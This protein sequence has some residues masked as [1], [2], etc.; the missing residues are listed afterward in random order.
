MKPFYESFEKQFIYRLIYLLSILETENGQVRA[1][2][3]KSV[4]RAAPTLRSFA[5]AVAL[6]EFGVAGHQS[7]RASE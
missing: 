3:E 4:E 5:G 6:C 1:K 7:Q 2:Y